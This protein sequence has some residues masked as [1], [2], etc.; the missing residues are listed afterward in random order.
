MN[1][2]TLLACLLLLTSVG[3]YGRT[4]LA[5]G[6]NAVAPPSRL[7]LPE[8]VEQIN[9]NNAKIPSLWATGYFEAFVI[10]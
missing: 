1:R 9:A 4:N 8:L 5:D 10:E 2:C 3:C 6:D 7:S